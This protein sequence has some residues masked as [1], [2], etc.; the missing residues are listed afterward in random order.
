MEEKDDSKITCHDLFAFCEAN[1]VCR[2]ESSIN[3]AGNVKV[4]GDWI[5]VNS[6]DIGYNCAASSIAHR[7]VTL[8]PELDLCFMLH[9]CGVDTNE[10]MD[11]I[12]SNNLVIICTN[13][14]VF[15]CLLCGDL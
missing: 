8:L 6:S 2:I 3:I 14:H 13:V 7:Y 9:A 12:T 1:I 11:T 10:L 15:L 5:N 4:F